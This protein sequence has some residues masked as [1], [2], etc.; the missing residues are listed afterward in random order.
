MKKIWQLIIIVPIIVGIV[1]GIGIAVSNQMKFNKENQKLDNIFASLESQPVEITKF[2]TYGTSLNLEGKLKGIKKDNYEGAKILVTNGEQTVEYKPVVTFDDYGLIFTS[3]T[4]INNAI[5]LESVGIGTYYINLRLKLNN[6][7][8]YK[9][10]SMSNISSCKNIE[11]FTLTK[12]EK[13]NK[14]NINFIEKEYNSKK[15]KTLSLNVKESELPEDVY[16]IVIDAGHGGT[17]KGE[18]YGEYNEAD[19]MLD[20]AISL[21]EKLEAKGYKVKLTRDETNTSTYT[22]T[23]MYDDD[24]RISIACSSKAKFMLSLH[25]NS[26]KD[27]GGIEVYAPCK[28]NLE[29]AQKL[30]NTIVSYTNI[31]YSSYDAYKKLDGVYVKNYNQNMIDNT[32]SVKKEYEN[33]PLTTDTPYLYTIREVGGIATNA[34][35]DGRNTMYS[36]NKYYKSNQGIECYQ[37]HFGSVKNNIN[38]ILTQKENFLS[39][40][41]SCF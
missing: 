6:S 4:E 34:Y 2:Y 16:D 25:L 17:D 19:L 11:Y 27:S 3:S 35:V 13:N 26:Q 18:K 37:I 32:N 21:K 1:I 40:I 9:Y 7:K 31:S 38:D 23:N 14:I 20:Y 39:A 41:V 36:A 22:S 24:G 10:Y 29:L 28:S 15:Y 30:A 5:D 8:D 12:E 33:Y